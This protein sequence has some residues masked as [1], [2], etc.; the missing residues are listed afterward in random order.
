[1]TTEELSDKLVCPHIYR[2][3]SRKYNS[4]LIFPSEPL[5]VPE[6]YYNNPCLACQGYDDACKRY[7]A[8]LKRAGKK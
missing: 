5:F 4:D 1:M 6:G 2:P 3:A 8:Y 7:I